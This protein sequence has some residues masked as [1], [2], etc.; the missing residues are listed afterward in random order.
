M[1]IDELVIELRNRDVKIFDEGHAFKLNAPQGTITPQLL[2]VITCYSAEL[3]YLVRIGDV[4][5]CPSRWEHRPH[6]RYS[7]SAEIFVCSAC[8]HETNA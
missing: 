4:R 7:P 1:T 8:R 6:W 5:V 3:L 2:E